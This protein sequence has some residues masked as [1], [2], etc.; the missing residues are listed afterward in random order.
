[1][2]VPTTRVNACIK[3]STQSTINTDTQKAFVKIILYCLC[4]TIN[5]LKI[6][7]ERNLTRILSTFES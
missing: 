1:M 5:E 2:F 4:I 7:T 6:K 3:S